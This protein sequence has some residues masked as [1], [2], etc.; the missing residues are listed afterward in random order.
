MIK[1]R[2]GNVIEDQGVMQEARPGK[3]VYLSLDARVQY[4]VYTALRD[5]VSFHNA[6]SALLVILYFVLLLLFF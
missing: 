3:D 1:D 6:K 5:A 2:L 4:I